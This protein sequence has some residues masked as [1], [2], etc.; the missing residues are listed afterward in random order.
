MGSV[1]RIITS[2]MSVSI[3]FSAVTGAS[4]YAIDSTTDNSQTESVAESSVEVTDDTYFGDSEKDAFEPSFEVFNI[5]DAYQDYVNST[6]TVTTAVT[7]TTEET[8]TTATSRDASNGLKGIDVSQWNVV[9]DWQ[10]VKDSGVEYAMI[11]AG[12]GK[13]ASQED[14]QFDNNMA[15]VKEVG[16]DCGVYWYSY[17]TTVEA[18]YQ[19]A[20]TC[21]NIIK[22]YQFEYPVVFDIEEDRHWALSTAEVSAIIETFCSYLEDKGYYVSLYSCASFLNTKVY[23]SV[24]DKYDIWVAHYGVSY[25]SVNHSYGMWQYSKTGSVSGISGDVDLDYAYKD[26]PFIMKRAHKNGY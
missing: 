11:R 5:Y 19:E 7:T 4:V 2:I 8:T 17:A 1:K 18:A 15:A 23:T 3:M 21:Y 26:Y 20:E 25:P 14:I 13:L 6:G 22:D 16:L 12:Y 10:Q 9:N 24:L